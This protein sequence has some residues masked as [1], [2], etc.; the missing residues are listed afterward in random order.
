MFNESYVVF[1]KEIIELLHTSIK[2]LLI[3]ILPF[4][5]SGLIALQDGSGGIMSPTINILCNIWLNI[6]Y[7]ELLCVAFELLNS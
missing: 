3:M 4:I 6:E 7:F 2:F 1:K 5:S